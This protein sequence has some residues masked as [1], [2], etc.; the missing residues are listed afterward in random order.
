M[1]PWDEFLTWARTLYDEKKVLVNVQ[2][3][4][5][6]NLQAVWVGVDVPS[7]DFTLSQFGGVPDAA[8]WT[9]SW[10]IPVMFGSGQLCESGEDAFGA[11]W[12][13]A[14][15]MIEA[16]AAARGPDWPYA[17][18]VAPVSLEPEDKWA[19]DDANQLQTILT[20]TLRV[21][22]NGLEP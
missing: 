4:D 1:N 15:R 3:G 12:A 10:E 7:I 17:W 18:L 22:T 6:P 20:L 16:I 21:E 11:A 13:N 8:D 2:R 5:L 19:E 14:K 9:T